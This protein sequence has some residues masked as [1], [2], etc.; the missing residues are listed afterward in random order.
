MVPKQHAYL[1]TLGSWVG[2]TWLSSLP[3][4]SSKLQ[5]L[6]YSYNQNNTNKHTLPT[7]FL[8]FCREGL[9]CQ[10]K[11][12]TELLLVNQELLLRNLLVLD[13]VKGFSSLD[14]FGFFLLGL[15]R[16]DIWAVRG[17]SNY[18]YSS[19]C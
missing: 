6:L 11:K 15:L 19:F 9:V 14:W 8:G 18:I 2:G 7:T 13:N 5:F 12:K 17:C 16:V 10:V 1:F 3:R 4:L